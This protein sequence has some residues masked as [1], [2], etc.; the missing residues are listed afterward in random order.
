MTFH[1]PTRPPRVSRVRG[2][3]L[4]PDEDRESDMKTLPNSLQI[5]LLR[6]REVELPQLVERAL[7]PYKS[8]VNTLTQ[9]VANLQVENKKLKEQVDRI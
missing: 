6:M 5:A 4:F 3:S 1:T 2:S 7:A 8:Q 9:N